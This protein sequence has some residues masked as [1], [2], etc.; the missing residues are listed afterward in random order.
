M[1]VRRGS[2][3]A[4]FVMVRRIMVVQGEMSVHCSLRNVCFGVWGL[5]CYFGV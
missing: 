3:G 4:P 1:A 2:L 5:G